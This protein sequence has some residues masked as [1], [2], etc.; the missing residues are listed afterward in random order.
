MKAVAAPAA[1]QRRA[2]AVTS[3]RDSTRAS[4]NPA[5]ISF[6]STSTCRAVPTIEIQLYAYS[7]S[8]CLC[9]VPTHHLIMHPSLRILRAK[10]VLTLS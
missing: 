9:V 8:L 1:H 3:S 2:R 10:P 7:T 5:G 6:L 4:G